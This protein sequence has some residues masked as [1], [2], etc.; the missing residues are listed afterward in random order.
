MKRCAIIYAGIGPYHMARLRAFA[1]LLPDLQAV[2]IAGTQRKYP[3]RSARQNLSFVLTT[4]F[5][6]EALETISWRRQCTALRSVLNDIQP[7]ILVVSGYRER[8]MRAAAAWASKRRIPAILLSP[9]THRDHP[10]TWWKELLKGCIVRRYTAVAATGQR[11]AEYAQRLGLPAR[12][13]FQIGNVV[14]NAH[15]AQRLGN[16]DGGDAAEMIGNGI[17][18]QFFVTVSRFS[19]E[20][21]LLRLLQAFSQYRRRQGSWDLVLVGSG[22]Q[23]VQLRTMAKELNVP[24]LYFVGWKGYEELP[25]YYARASCFILPSISESWGLAVNEAMAC[26][27]PILVSENCGCVPELCDVGIN[28]YTFDPNSVDQL[29]ELMLRVSSNSGQLSAMGQASQRIIASFAPQTWAAGLRDCIAAVM[30][31]KA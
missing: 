28:G 26:G 25:V 11:A 27:L 10:R 4:L 2:E 29:T 23:E 9:S 19:P 31:E 3:W 16:Q 30:Q 22:P 12:S 5:P 7:D 6:R 14:H 24:G 1:E 17:S 21:N 15:F 20:K 8:V 18:S 13:I